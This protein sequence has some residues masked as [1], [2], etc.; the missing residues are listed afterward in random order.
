MQ[1]KQQTKQEVLRQ[2]NSERDTNQQDRAGKNKEKGGVAS[3][4]PGTGIKS[5]GCFLPDLTRFTF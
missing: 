1:W 4:T 2:S 3:P 5:C